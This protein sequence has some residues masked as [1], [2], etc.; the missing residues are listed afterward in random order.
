MAFTNYFCALSNFYTQSVLFHH[1]YHW[2][3][4]CEINLF[5]IELENCDYNLN[6]KLQPGIVKTDRIGICVSVY[7]KHFSEKFMIVNMT[8]IMQFVV[9]LFA[10]Y[11]TDLFLF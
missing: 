11:Y 1:V 3:S 4:F 7:R 2:F 5:F 9:C 6:H 10:C 8:M